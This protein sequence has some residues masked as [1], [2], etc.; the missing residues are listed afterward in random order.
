MRNGKNL[1]SVSA[2][3]V[4]VLVCMG[5][6][7]AQ[8]SE[9]MSFLGNWGEGGGEIRAVSNFGDL[10]YYGVGNVLSIVS[11]E[12]PASPF[13]A[14]SVKL[15]DMVEDIVWFTKSGV[16][17]CVVSG[18]SLNIVDVTNPV[19]PSLVS[20]LSL[21]GYGEGLDISG[22]YVYV[23]VGGS[24]MEVINISDPANPSSVAVVAGAGSGY[25]EGINVSSPYAYL[26]N[27]ANV[28][29]FD[30]NNPASPALLSSYENSGGDWIQDAMPISNYLYVCVW[31]TGID[32]LDLSNI[33]S[34]SYVTTFANPTNADI[35]FDGNYGYIASRDHGLTVMDVSSPGSPTLV[36]TFGTD[37]SLR[38]VSFGA[39]TIDQQIKGHI[40]S[41]EVSQLGAIN[42]SDAAG[43]MNYSGKTTVAAPAEG[44]AY[45]SIVRG[46]LAYVAYGNFGV[47]VL[48][49]SSPSNIVE[50]GNY[51]TGG[52]SRKIVLKEDIA[53]VANRNGGLLVLD[54]SNSEAPDSITKLID[55]TVN[56]VAISGDYIY[57]AARDLGI[58]I[59]NI[60]TANSPAEVGY[61]S[62]YYGEGVAA[63]GAVMG[64]STWDK[65]YFYDISS[66]ES[67]VLQDS[68]RL[69]TGTGEFAIYGDYAYVHDYDTLRIYSIADLG[70]VEEIGKAFTGGSWDGTVSVDGDYAYANAETNGVRVFDITDKS[71][72]TEVGHYDGTNSARGVYAI[73]G[74]AYVS[75]KEGGL[76]IY[77]NELYV[78]V[79]DP[80]TV[81]TSFTLKQNYPNPFN[82]VTVIGYTIPAGKSMVK[83][84]VFNTQGQH[85]RTLVNQEQLSGPY[86]VEWNGQTESGSFAPTGVYFY[87]LSVGDNS[88]SRKMILLK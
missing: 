40:F 10:V 38:K 30:I 57:S 32:V 20:T 4:M 61:L 78:S 53:Y 87:R 2:I 42:V 65:V 58:A 49:V 15:D 34:P 24:G 23:A 22:D 6:L 14:G 16:T 59:I 84:E 73:N 29:I 27:G 18:T 36:N 71:N 85:I 45:S 37:G 76:A 5:S 66:P 21:A 80:K 70:N 43:G 69:A 55:G 56:D 50:M 17:Y 81:P 68:V 54:V 75:E 3:L 13:K 9:N 25:A 67:P 77:R 44:I 1:L 11:F 79:K 86:S 83:L 41:A 7:N 8:S 52:S 35:M 12:N 88:L 74:L 72:P 82:P 28:S 64:Q 46:N 47:R 26:G 63:D 19:T 60:S 39:I 62:D 51:V 31:G 33:S 48:D